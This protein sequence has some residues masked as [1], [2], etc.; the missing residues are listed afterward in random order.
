VLARLLL[1]PAGHEFEIYRRPLRPETNHTTYSLVSVG[2]HIGEEWGLQFSHQRG[3]D[4]DG[5]P[6]FEAASVSGQYRWSEK[7]EF[8]GRESFSLLENQ[9]LDTKVGLRR[10]GHDIV[11]EIEGGVREGEGGTFGIS[12]KPRFGYHPPRVGYVPW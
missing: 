2:T 10:Y 8:E 5:Q 11:F 6:L 1:Q 12:M 4:S 7:W 3:L 9:G